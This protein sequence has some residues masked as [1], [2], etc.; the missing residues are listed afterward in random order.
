MIYR[1]LFL[2]LILVANSSFAKGAYQQPEEF[3]SKAF[4]QQPEPQVVWVKGELRTQIEHIL[5]HK[6]NARRIRYWQLDK[7][8]VWV[9]DEIGK[10]KPITVGIIIDDNKISELKVLVFRER[11][12]AGKCVTLFSPNSS[13]NF[14]LKLTIA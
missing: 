5:Q 2:C 14:H 7:R 4:T 13:I 3:V 6:Y 10:K 1:L 8:S 12:E 11:P 9:L